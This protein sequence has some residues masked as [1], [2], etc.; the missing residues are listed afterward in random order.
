MCYV[1]LSC[2][3]QKNAMIL[4]VMS[5]YIVFSVLLF[6]KQT[7]KISTIRAQDGNSPNKTFS[8]LHIKSLRL[9]PLLKASVRRARQILASSKATGMKGESKS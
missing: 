4:D 1:K 6:A 7:H 2:I 9:H 3:P 5:K 8:S